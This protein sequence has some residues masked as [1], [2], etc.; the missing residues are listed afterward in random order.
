MNWINLNRWRFVKLTWTNSSL[1][2]KRADCGTLTDSSADNICAAWTEVLKI[3]DTM[4]LRSSY[5]WRSSCGVNSL[6]P[7][8]PGSA[9]LFKI[10]P[11]VSTRRKDEVLIFV[12][13]IVSG[14]FARACVTGRWR[15]GGMDRSGHADF[16]THKLLFLPKIWR[17]CSGFFYIGLEVKLRPV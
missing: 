3:K 7:V 11:S 4:F 2:M 15:V 13:S 17:K 9:R 8:T 1:C 10:I 6:E 5:S 12:F 16:S 14:V